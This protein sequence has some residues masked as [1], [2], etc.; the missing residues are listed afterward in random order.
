MA[1]NSGGPDSDTITTVSKLVRNPLNRWLLLAVFAGCAT[2]EADP[3]N[4][5]A[6]ELASVTLADDCG[7][8]P[9]PPA[10]KPP[11]TRP[12]AAAVKECAGP[13]CGHA[14]ACDQTSMQLSFKAPAGS[15]ATTI[16]IKKVELLDAKGKLLEV[17]SARAP[18]RFADDTYVAWDET[19][20]PSATLATMYELNSPNWDKLTN[21]RWSAHNATFQLRVTVAIGSASKT[22]EKQSITPVRL[23]PPVPT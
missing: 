20:A 15:K 19:I 13:K 10:A 22:V 4:G 5:V 7:N 3:S 11:A 14:R 18:S 1:A 6:V 2:S 16:K 23:A 12:A 8:P 9:P 17:L 21:G